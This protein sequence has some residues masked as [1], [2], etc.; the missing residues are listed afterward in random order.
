MDL[1]DIRYFKFDGISAP[2][3]ATAPDLTEAGL[4]NCEAI[5]SIEREVRR[6]RPDLFFNTTVG[7]WASHFWFHASDAVWCQEG[8]IGK[9]G[10]SD[11]REQRI[12]NRNHLV[13]QNFVQRSPLY[14]IDTLIT[15]GLILARF[16]DVSKRM[17]YDGVVREMRCA[18][19]YTQPQILQHTPLHLRHPRF[20]PC[21]HHALQFFR[22]A[23]L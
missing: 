4:E 8:D 10:V 2:F 20:H 7:T 12:T 3:S 9:M 16:G 13:Y 18:F 23:N 19:D 15:C 1:Y 5:I 6:K 17:D 21:A 14:P 11:D 22:R